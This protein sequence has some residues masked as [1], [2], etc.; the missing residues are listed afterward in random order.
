MKPHAI[1]EWLLPTTGGQ[2]RDYLDGIL[3]R[4]QSPER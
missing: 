4:L 3:A 1:L 2:S